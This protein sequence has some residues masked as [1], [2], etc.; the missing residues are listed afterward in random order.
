MRVSEIRF[1]P[2]GSRT[3]SLVRAAEECGIAR[4]YWDIFHKRHEV[5]LEAQERILAALGWDVSSYESME[6]E[7]QRHFRQSFTCPLGKTSVVSE[8]DKAVLITVSGAD[9]A[10]LCY[11][12]DLE[13]G[14]AV[15]GSIDLAQLPLARRVGIED[16][17]WSAYKLSLPAEVPLGYHRLKAALNGHSIGETHVIVCPD[18]A[19]LPENLRSSGKT[20]GFNVSLYGLRSDRNWG[21]GDFTDLRPLIDWARH[22][23]GFSFIGLNPLH[24]L[25]NRAP[26][27]TSPYLPLSIYYKNL[28]YID[29]ESVPEFKISRSAQCLASSPKMQQKIRGLREAELVCYEE[30]DRLKRCF[31]KLLYREFRRERARGSERS[32]AF[33]RYSHTEGDLLDKFALY[34]AL[35]EALHKENRNLWTWRDWAPE[36]QASES[37][38]VE[39]FSRQHARSVEFYKYIQFIAD[40]QLQAA[41]RFARESGMSI[42]L[43]HDLA[44]ATDSCGSDLWGYRNFYANGCRVG[45]PPDDFSPQGQDWGFP[46]PSAEAHRENGYC[47]FRDT[48]RKIVAYGGALRID[49]VMRLFRLFWIPEGM[50]ARHGAYVRD[51]AVDLMRILALESVRSKNV[52]IGEDLGTVTDEIREMLAGFGIL[53]YRLFYFEK[54]QTGAAFKP[55]REYSRQA[56]VSSTT[57]DLPTLAGFWKSRDIEARRA[58]GLIDEA[59]Y[60]AQMNQRKREKQL[61]LDRLHSENLLPEYYTRRAE[62]VFELDGDLHNAV[63]GFLA[64]VPSMILLLNQEDFTKEADQQNLPGSTAQYPNWQRKMRAKVEDLRSPQWAG[65]TAMLRNQLARTGRS[66]R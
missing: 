47:L 65:Y 61:M 28:I 31:L 32:L 23:V 13:G 41:Q 53:S 40:E 59:G 8:S 4:E 58:A 19:H 24:A 60:L 21:C 29:I 33:L 17:V 36:Y 14:Q 52:I 15:A 64:Q 35:D 44:V 37:K 63:M 18:E 16:Q 42:G 62:Q 43:Y 45:A 2:A 10:S 20:A 27:N 56:L 66:S 55:S 25:H 57:H 26:Y 3:E 1:L 51:H 48:I 39:L 9:N 34:C 5:S 54:D 50:E 6:A 49:H 30:V 12:V 7:R 11:E 38:A 46:P 22:E